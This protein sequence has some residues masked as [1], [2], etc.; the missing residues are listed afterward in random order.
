MDSQGIDSIELT[1]ELC[2][3]L[4]SNGIINLDFSARKTKPEL[5]YKGKNNQHILVA[6][7][8]STGLK[9][10]DQSFLEKLLKA[11]ELTMDDVALVNMKDLE[12]QLSEVIRQLQIKKCILFGIPLLSIDLP[13][14]SAE[15]TAIIFDD[16]YF[17]RTASLPSLQHDAAKKKALWHALKNMFGV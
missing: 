16:K 13:I 6:I 9:K 7:D 1:S 15:E 8:V 10:D 14:G 12:V 4:Y 5:I 3:R 2:R 11:C 17:I